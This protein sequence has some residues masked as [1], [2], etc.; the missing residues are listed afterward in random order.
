MRCE[1]VRRELHQTARP[2]E[3]LAPELLAHLDA[4]PACRGVHLELV[5]LRRGLQ[6][7]EAPPLPDGF[8]LALRSRLKRA[9]AA[10]TARSAAPRQQRWLPIALAASILLAVGAVAALAL[11]YLDEQPEVPGAAGHQ[12]HALRLSIG[13]PVDHPEALFDVRLPPGVAL[14]RA[15]AR[16]LGEGPVLRWRSRLRAGRNAIELPLVAREPGSVR[17]EVR[18][19]GRSVATTVELGARAERSRRPIVVALELHLE[20]EA[21]E[22]L[23]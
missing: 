9:D 20:G 15:A 19:G 3:P 16:S 23:R 12:L 14:T 18:V 13:T 7:L 22:V 1:Q 6:G 17:I 11:S 21:T 10:R 2:E 4:C 8:A 5:A